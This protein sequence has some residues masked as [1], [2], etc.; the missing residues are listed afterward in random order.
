MTN[1]TLGYLAIGLFC[2]A[3]ALGGL[4]RFCRREKARMLSDTFK[5]QA[6]ER[7]YRGYKEGER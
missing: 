2:F 4:I 1:E 3:A 7:T 6:D 5:P